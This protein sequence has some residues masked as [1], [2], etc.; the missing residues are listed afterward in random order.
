MGTQ[1]LVFFAALSL[2]IAWYGL[3]I[4]E[5]DR[6][7]QSSAEHHAYRAQAV[8]L[9]YSGV[10]VAVHKLGWEKPS[11]VS[12]LAGEVV[13]DEG[14]VVYTV[15]DDGLPN[16]EKQARVTSV[17]TYHGY[18]ATTVAIL[19]CV[20]FTKTWLKEKGKKKWFSWE[21]VS[22]KT[23]IEEEKKSGSSEPP[24]EIDD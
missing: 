11:Q 7:V 15:D 4:K 18:N 1:A 19:E 6:K 3:N 2:S 8:Q 16:K 22:V 23:T 5:A 17:A 21:T 10:E 13:L 14:S 9:A 24:T 12:N 20:G